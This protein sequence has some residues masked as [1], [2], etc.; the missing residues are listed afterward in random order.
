MAKHIEQLGS[1]ESFR[2]PW[3]T[4]GGSDAEIEKPKLRRWIF[5]LLSDKAKAQDSRDEA[6]EALAAAEKERDEAKE[7]AAKAS[8]DEANKKIEKLEKEN[9]ELKAAAAARKKADEHEELRRDVTGDLDPKYAKYVQ[10]DDREALEK[11]LEDVKADFGIGDTNNV[12]GDGD[13]TPARTA[14]RTSIRNP[15]DPD[16]GKGS[17]AIDFDKVADQILGTSVFG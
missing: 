10:G 15:L 14:P 1:L 12:D 17:D 16:N 7:E 8:P 4:E 3:E 6:V 13:E 2:A 5:N 9:G 11:S